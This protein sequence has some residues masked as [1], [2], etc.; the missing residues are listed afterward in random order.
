MCKLANEPFEIAFEAYT[1]IDN[2]F[3]NISSMEARQLV[4][5]L[6]NTTIIDKNIALLSENL[7]AQLRDVE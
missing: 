4:D 3:D 1:L 6:E 2:S 5:L 7:I